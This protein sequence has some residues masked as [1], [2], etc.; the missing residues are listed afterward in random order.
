[1][2]VEL[3]STKKRVLECLRQWPD[4]RDSDERLIVHIWRSEIPYQKLSGEEVLRIMANGTLTN[5]E[6]IRRSRQLIQKDNPEL[7]GKSYVHRQKK[8][9]D[10][11]KVI[12]EGGEVVPADYAYPKMVEFWLKD[13]H[14]GWSFGKMHGSAI[15]SLIKKIEVLVKETLKNEQIEARPE[16]IASTFIFICRN[17]PDW[18]RCKDLPVIDS[19]FNEIVEE[20]KNKKNGTTKNKSTSQ[21]L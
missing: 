21:Y 7:R 19:K 15:K 2:E 14:P 11:A 6:S 10:V 17:L 16:V 12:R 5:T 18:F 3:E 4:L 9:Q 1:M 13:F 20:I 8:S